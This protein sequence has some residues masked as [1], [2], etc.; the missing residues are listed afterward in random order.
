MLAGCFVANE[1]Y[2]VLKKISP[3]LDWSDVR[4][5]ARANDESLPEALVTLIQGELWRYLEDAGYPEEG[6]LASDAPPELLLK[7][8]E[9]ELT[10]ENVL[11]ILRNELPA[12]S[13]ENKG[14]KSCNGEQN[15]PS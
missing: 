6:Q 7:L 15:W 1:L 11:R 10:P 12:K 4:E 14:A 13:G 2:E 3:L 8:L 5:V 9:I